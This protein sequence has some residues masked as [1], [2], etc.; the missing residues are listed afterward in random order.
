[1]DLIV[2]QVS[3]FDITQLN[4]IIFNELFVLS[5]HEHFNFLLFYEGASLLPA[6]L[7]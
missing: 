7:H 2:G 4:A 3:H 6:F 1:M 5:N